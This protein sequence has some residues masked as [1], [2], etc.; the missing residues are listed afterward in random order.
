[1][2]NP[3]R[4]RLLAPFDGHDGGYHLYTARTA[5]PDSGAETISYAALRPEQQR[6]FDRARATDTRGV[7]IAPEVDK[8][9]WFDYRYV[10]YR[11]RTYRAA[12]APP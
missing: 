5:Q 1:M 11:G 4:P 2:Q 12:V 6:V 3:R 9:V 7:E 8:Q 10:R